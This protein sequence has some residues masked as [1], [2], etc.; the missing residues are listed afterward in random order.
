MALILKKVIVDTIADLSQ[1]SVED[2]IA[3]RIDKFCAMGVFVE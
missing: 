1:L 3:K 2:R